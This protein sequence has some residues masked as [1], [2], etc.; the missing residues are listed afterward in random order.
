[1][2][3]VG[4]V[5]IQIQHLPPSKTVVTQGGGGPEPAKTAINTVTIGLQRI[6]LL[7]IISSLTFSLLQFGL[8]V[9]MIIINIK[10]NS[11]LIYCYCF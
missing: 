2:I 11:M 5:T 4:N 9:L 1:M 3:L 6:E 8:I 7:F 10:N